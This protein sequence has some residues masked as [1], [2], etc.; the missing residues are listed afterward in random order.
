MKISQLYGKTITSTNGR[1]KGVILGVSC[2]KNEI[3]GL[4]CCDENETR[5]FV[6]GGDAVSLCG[7][8][9]FVKT[10]KAQK[11]TASLKLGKAVYSSQGKF[12]GHLED[13]ILSGLKITHA[14]VGGKKMPFNNLILG[15]VCI[16]KSKTKTAD[17]SAE[18]A[19]KNMFIQAVCADGTGA[20]E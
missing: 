11:N 9:Q 7:E 13:C 6:A 14:V 19:A 20:V 1:K 18:L 17:L 12:L 4:I 10:G 5:F 8:T 16:V 2:V 15:D 3:D